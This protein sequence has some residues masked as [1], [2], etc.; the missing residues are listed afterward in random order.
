MT[1]GFRP[2]RPGREVENHL[3]AQAICR[4]PLEYH[5]NAVSGVAARTGQAHVAIRY[6]RLLIYIEDWAAMEALGYAVRRA[7]QLGAEVL[8]PRGTE[9]EATRIRAMQRFER[10]GKAPLRSV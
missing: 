9:E 7:E 4:G 3:I 8:G 1:K 2:P 5:V 10:T 6:G